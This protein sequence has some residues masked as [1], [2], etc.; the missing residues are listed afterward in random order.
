MKQK[1]K[2]SAQRQAMRRQRL[3]ADGFDQRIA[4]VHKQD[5]ERYDAFIEMLR[6]PDDGNKHQQ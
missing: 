3:K 5:R 2:T 6:K 1:P 4:W